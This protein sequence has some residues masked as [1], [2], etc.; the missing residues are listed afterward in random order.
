[1]PSDDAK[2]LGVDTP[3]SSDSSTGQDAGAAASGDGEVLERLDGIVSRLD[4]VSDSLKSIED[5]SSV[6]SD[7][8]SMTVTLDAAQYDALSSRAA[9]NTYFVFVTAIVGFCIFGA[10]I[11]QVFSYRWEL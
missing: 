11:W 7:A 8:A 3:A 9:L 4:G 10:V 6:K 2:V 1:M 5:G